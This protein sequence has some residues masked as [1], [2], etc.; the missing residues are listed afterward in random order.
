MTSKPIQLTI[1]K[2][3]VESKSRKLDLRWTMEMPQ[4]LSSVEQLE[5]LMFCIMY[6][7]GVREW[8]DEFGYKT[9]FNS[10]PHNPEMYNV[11][12]IR[13]AD[14]AHFKLVWC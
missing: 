3:R 7:P 8:I 9:K 13:A 10:D 4:P 2:T 1:I 5:G 12:F 14:A 6:T 11:T